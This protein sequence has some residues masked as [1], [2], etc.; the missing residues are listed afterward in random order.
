MTVTT[1]TTTKGPLRLIGVWSQLDSDARA[2]AVARG[3]EKIFDPTLRDRVCALLDDVRTNGDD[4]LVRALATYDGCTVAPDRLRVADEEFERA[5]R[6]VDPGLLTAIR[7]SIDHVRRFNE[8][9]TARGDWS[10]ES[11]PGLTVGEKVGPIASAGLFVP[12]GKGSYPSVLVQLGTP[13]RVAGV[14]EIAV[15]VPPVPGSD[16]RVD[17]AVLVVAAELGLRQVFRANG[18][19]GIAALAFGTETV[20]KVRKVV[21]PGSPAVTC[22]QVEVQRYGTVTSMLL[23]PSESLILAD[24][25]ADVPLLAADL[26]NEAEHGPDSSSVLVTDSRTLL[27][28]VQREVA[29]QLA[30]LPE[31]RRGYAELALGVNG[32]AVLVEDL[33]EGA[34]VANQYA[35]EHMQIA[36]RDEDAVLDLLHDAGE[37][38]VGQWT[39][40]SAANFVIGCPAALP[41]SGF[42]KVN[43]GVTAEAFLKRTAVARADARA[44]ARMSG[45]VTAFTRHEGFPAHEAAVRIRLDRAAHGAQ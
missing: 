40:V 2:R 14:P 12:S 35:P 33:H 17:D 9:L 37:I 27:E 3:T 22:A 43:G 34:E 24:D 25:S 30:L 38:L 15:V 21:G 6:T 32:G 44:L 28:A 29:R 10:F 1:T 45:T 23:G 16:G 36:V 31:P 7:D 19:S 41:T 13:A 39:P 18:P 8:Y 4:A 5:R 26:L 20:P 42:A 11:E